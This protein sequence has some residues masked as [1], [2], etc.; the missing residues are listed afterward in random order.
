MSKKNN[1]ANVESAKDSTAPFDEQV[2]EQYLTPNPLSK[3]SMDTD[4]LRLALVTAQ[5]ALRATRQ[6]AEPTPDKAIGLLFRYCA[7]W[8]EFVLS[9]ASAAS[10]KAFGIMG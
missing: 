10:C 5:F 6:P 1:K 3:F 2:I 9:I 4:A 8:S 7:V